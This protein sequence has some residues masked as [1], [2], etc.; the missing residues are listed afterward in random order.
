M[1]P[2]W[3]VACLMAAAIALALL[4]MTA[5]AA[6]L[7]APQP[8]SPTTG[9]TVDQ[10]L[11]SW[12]AVNGAAHY[13]IE[14]ALD[15]QFVT[16]TDP[17]DEMEPRV[18]HGTTYVPTRS[19]TAKHHYW[20]VRAVSPDGTEGEWSPTQE[21]TRRWT[22]D[23]EP[24]GT[25]LSGPAS[26]V[27][28][29]RTVSGGST[30]ALNRVAFTWDPVP[31]AAYYQVQVTAANGDSI[32]CSTPHNV[33]APPFEGSYRLRGPLSGCTGLMS[34]VRE[35][36]DASGWSSAGPGTVAIEAE[37]VHSD[38]LVFVRF[39]D[40]DGKHAEV[41][42]WEATVT[43]VGGD[44]LA[45][46]VPA[47]QLPTDPAAMAQY[48]VVGLPMQ[49]H[50]QY[51]V[52][53]RAVDIPTEADYPAAP[54]HGM[55]SDERREPG[56]PLPAHVVI[57]PDEAAAGTGSWATP[58]VPDDPAID[59]TDTPLLSWEPVPG[60]VAYRVVVAVD[61]DFTDRVA[62]YQTRAATF[63]PP[64]TYDDAAPNRAYYWFAVPSDYSVIEETEVQPLV[65][66]RLAIN[67][68]TY[69]GRFSKHSAQVTGLTTVDQDASTNVLLRWG[70][71]L[72]A[73]QDLNPA[74]TPGGVDKY[75]VQFTSTTWAQSSSV[76]T[77]N[78]AYSTAADP[79]GSGTYRWR[80]R[81]RDGQGVPL[82]WAY[83]PDF[84]I[85]QPDD[86]PPSP[87][88][89]PTPSQSTPGA[90]PTPTEGSGVPPLPQPT[91][92]A[93][94][95]ADGTATAIPP[96][97]PGKPSV[98]RSGKRK[99]RVHWRASEE[100]GEPVS[101]YVVY[102][103]TD[104]AKFSVAKRTTATAVKVRAKR[105]A[106]YWFYIVADS[107]AGPSAPSTTARFPK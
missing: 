6:V 102:R 103:S 2:R 87:S 3:S 44:P 23:D 51:R 85:V 104:G 92:Q 38:D 68:P 50:Q 89:T 105:K 32:T 9:A 5:S 53:V 42:P 11:F 54:V 78:L 83:G 88:P 84:T 59:S 16:V 97:K 7:P 69:I 58:V 24:A 12:A 33:L 71:A 73:A 62:E 1:K 80:V 4:P 46:T 47:S 39:L 96:E 45:F 15:D 34:P 75:E 21:F 90:T 77:D 17:G 95:P 67:D 79:L 57:T 81:P 72:T 70:D 31:G 56:E 14:V 63:M 18:V 25:E 100:L 13:E 107:D 8:G 40:S 66:D 49:P 28:N 94:A 99:L 29:V 10:P 93:P 98:S 37:D 101:Q 106:T 26:R 35:W 41:D 82:A 20:H 36:V 76:L 30:P 64:E 61:R 52:R 65:P 60:A 74:F 19:L 22:N 55:W 43:S 48:F 86:P 91:Y 27:E